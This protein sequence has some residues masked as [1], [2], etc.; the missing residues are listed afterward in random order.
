MEG[1]PARSA[2]ILVVDDNADTAALAKIILEDA[3]HVVDIAEDGERAIA[4][5][6]AK[7][8]DLVLLDVNLPRVNGF[9]VCKTIKGRAGATGPV[10]LM[11]T[12]SDFHADRE[13]ARAAGAD[14]YLVKP[15]Q[16]DELVEQVRLALG[17]RPGTG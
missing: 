8:F 5:E 1:P 15:F 6:N 3:G 10:V 9:E 17:S 11:F 2:R 4:I 7:S 12:V 14:G 13:T 16:A